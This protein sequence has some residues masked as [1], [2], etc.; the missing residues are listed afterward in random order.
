[1]QEYLYR[2]FESQG[3]NGFLENASITLIGKTDGSGL[4]KRE[5]F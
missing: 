2:H 3:H 1:M 4:T 5:I